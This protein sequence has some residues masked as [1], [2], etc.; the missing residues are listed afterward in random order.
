MP[1]NVV[2]FDK[3]GVGKKGSGK[4]WTKGEV[5]RRAA[6]AQELQRKKTKPPKPPAWVQ[7]DFEVF[8]VWQQIIK[9]SKGINLLDVLD[10]NVLATY[11]KLEVEK[12]HAV[13]QGDIE[14]FERL[15]KTSLQ[16]AKSLG[17]TP[18]AR[19]RLA[20]GR[21]EKKGAGDPNAHL[22]D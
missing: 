1:T 19:A 14:T 15:S 3:M 22:F 20:K 13:R 8:A 7:N 6:A 21:A 10:A 18:E 12:Q 4:H 16:Y 5:E 11:C 9:D 2:S 17:L